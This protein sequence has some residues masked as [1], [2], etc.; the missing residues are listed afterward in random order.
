MESIDYEALHAA[1]LDPDDPAEWVTQSRMQLLLKSRAVQLGWPEFG[2][3][4][5]R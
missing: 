5:R 4:A 1:G 3:G 2:P